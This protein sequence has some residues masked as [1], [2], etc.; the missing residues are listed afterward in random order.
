[1]K[2]NPTQFEPDAKAATNRALKPITE[3]LMSECLPQLEHYTVGLWTVQDDDL[4]HDRTGVL[5][6]VA[7]QHFILTASHVEDDGRTLQNAILASLPLYVSNGKLDSLPVPLCGPE[8]GFHGTEASKPSA[9]D[10][11]AIRLDTET[12]EYLKSAKDFLRHYRIRHHDD[13][14]GIYVI[15][16]Y[17]R[18][19]TD[20]SSNGVTEH[21]LF[22]LA[23]AFR[24]NFPAGTRYDRQVHIALEFTRDALEG[25]SG[26]A[27]AL[28]DIHGISGC[29]IWR[30]A[31]VID[32]TPW[33]SPQHEPQLVAI[34]HSWSRAGGY[35]L[36]T[37]I[38]HVTQRI[39]DDYPHLSRAMNLLYPGSAC[40]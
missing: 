4:R 38:A 20:D 16:G 30:I 35:V 18:A 22:F 19:W 10:I 6:A 13:G 7:D 33:R 37:R 8:C 31:D 39:H 21:P 29:G 3:R 26:N 27:V 5:Y 23:R 25:D 9:R 40:F 24:G 32:S 12:V 11:C 14:H 28:P 17:P 2:T 36:G 1:M 34:E 15:A